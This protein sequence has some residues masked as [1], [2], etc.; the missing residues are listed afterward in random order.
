MT[1]LDKAKFT[2]KRKKPVTVKQTKIKNKDISFSP[3]ANPVFK[4]GGSAKPGLWS[5][6][7]RR[8]RLGI[9]RPKSESTISKKAYEN[10]RKGFPKAKGGFI[11]RGCGKVMKNRK[12][13]TK[14][15]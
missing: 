13:I 6:I 9:S 10:M 15:Y 14:V 11:A 7:N 8:K 12:K 2:D 5:N 3:V 1:E 4:E